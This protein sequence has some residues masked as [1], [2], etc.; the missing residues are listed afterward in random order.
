MKFMN[1][2]KPN[3][4]NYDKCEYVDLTKYQLHKG[5]TKRS[6]FDNGFKYFANN[7]FIAYKYLYKDIIKLQI[8]I[9]LDSD[10]ENDIQVDIID[11]YT[12]K[13]YMPVWYNINGANN[14]VAMEALKNF[15]NYMDELQKRK[16]LYVG[17]MEEECKNE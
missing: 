17:H 10:E 15:K 13:E 6:L 1:K 16:I 9:N 14:L 4:S 3:A 5:L 8:I 2:L 7:I 12:G 11:R